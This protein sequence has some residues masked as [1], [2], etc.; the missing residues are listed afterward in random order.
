MRDVL[1]TL[2]LGI[3]ALVAPA[4]C[5]ACGARGA[6]PWCA[7]CAREAGR[8]RILPGCD[9][10]GADAGGAH[11]C[12]PEAGPVTTSTSAFRYQGVVAAAVVAGKVR[13]AWAVWDPLGRLLA[14]A[15]LARTAP[16]VDVVTWVPTEPRRARARG[17]DHA[18]V[19][20]RTVATALVVPAHR[21]LVNGPPR[22]DQAARPDHRRRH[23]PSSAFRAVGDLRGARVLLVDDVLTTGG[24]VHAAARVLRSSHV[25][26]V[27]VLTLARAGNHPL[28]P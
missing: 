24:T 22:P 4:R 13:G 16:S 7:G 12:W 27:E 10:C 5:V 2:T 3:A 19:L 1:Q 14:A 26:S 6:Q 18:E 23:V 17:V 25:G 21:A 20:A 9:R 15:T 11:G 28:G 8:L